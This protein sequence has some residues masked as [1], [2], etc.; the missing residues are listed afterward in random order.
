VTRDK[1]YDY[2]IRSRYEKFGQKP[3]SFVK[4]DENLFQAESRLPGN[5][6]AGL[7]VTVL[8]SLI[9]LGIS[10]FVLRRRMNKIPEDVKRPELTLQE[11]RSYFMFFKDAAYRDST[12]DNYIRQENVSGIDRVEIEDIDFE[13]TPRAAVKLIS[14][15]RGTDEGEVLEYLEIMGVSQQELNAKRNTPELLRKIYAA[16]QI[17]GGEIIVINEF[18]KDLSRSFEKDFLKLVKELKSRGK[19]FV[20]MS[21]EFLNLEIESKE[22]I[23]EN[24]IDY[25]FTEMAIENA[26]MR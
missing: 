13:I 20:Y 24:I 18:L 9:L 8:Y 16:S 2:Y 15:I 6:Y 12:F 4:S 14:S 17:V 23:E 7:G 19:M 1:F 11:G 25:N 10:F 3:E 22:R 5:Y 21:I 26:S